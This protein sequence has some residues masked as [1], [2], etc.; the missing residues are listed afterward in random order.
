M[1]GPASAPRRGGSAAHGSGGNHGEVD[2][3]KGKSETQDNPQG[4]RKS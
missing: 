4:G 2:G 3:G 1:G